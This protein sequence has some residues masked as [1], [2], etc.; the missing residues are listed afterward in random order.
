VLRVIPVVVIAGINVDV[1]VGEPES[2]GD[3]EQPLVDVE[4]GPRNRLSVAPRIVASP[5][6][7]CCN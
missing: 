2:L 4:V 5:S 1:E 7:I 3:V 6:L